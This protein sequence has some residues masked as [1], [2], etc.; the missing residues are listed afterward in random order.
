MTTDSQQPP[1]QKP[2]PQKEHHWLK[3]LVGEWTF[4]GEASMGPDTPPEKFS[5]TESVRSIGDVW[6]LAEG[7]GAMPSG[8]ASTSMATLG[9]DPQKKRFVGTFIGSMMTNMWVYDGSLDAAE[10]VLTLDTE[11][12]GMS[13][14]GKIARYQDVIEIKS[15][16]E[17]TMLSRMQ[18]EDGS[19][20]QFM[21]MTY[22]RTK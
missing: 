15:S 6:F 10:K 19:W 13:G 3:Q 14:D 22:R 21:T 11:G 18:G 5:G 20:T 16:D 9:F 8:G 2:E 1:M 12:P 7:Q 17:R 4:E